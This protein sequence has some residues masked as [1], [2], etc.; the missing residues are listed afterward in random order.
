MDGRCWFD[1]KLLHLFTYYMH[2]FSYMEHKTP[3]MQHRPRA[4]CTFLV[5]LST[6]YYL[7]AELF[8]LDSIY[9]PRYVAVIHSIM[10]LYPFFHSKIDEIPREK[11][12]Q[13]SSL[14]ANQFAT[15][16]GRHNLWA[17]IAR[18]RYDAFLASQRRKEQKLPIAIFTRTIMVIIYK[19]SEDNPSTEKA[20]Y[21]Q[22]TA[23]FPWRA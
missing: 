23:P 16:V 10:A 14:R 3:R 4:Y 7:G 2:S 5:Q 12:S 6:S 15:Y 20:K 17:F 18:V 8:R 21:R 19:E 1:S 9:L 22:S 11:Q 13:G